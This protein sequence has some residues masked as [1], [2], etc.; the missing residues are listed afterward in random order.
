MRYL[1][2]IIFCSY[3]ISMLGQE[4]AQRTVVFNLE[5][6]VAIQGYDPVAYFDQQA[7]KGKK[8][9]AVTHQGVTYH[10]AS[11]ANQ[12]KF[13][14]NPAHYEPQYGGWCAYAMG[15]NG[16]KVKVNPKTFKIV[17]DKLY[18]FYNAFFNNTLEPW[19]EDEANLKLMADKNWGA[20]VN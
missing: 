9:Y 10:F 3:S 12:V 13:Q 15:L 16:E 20:I 5:K 19:N 14:E 17:E 1:I 4:H 7:Q 18:L 6:G 2:V 11:K 8:K